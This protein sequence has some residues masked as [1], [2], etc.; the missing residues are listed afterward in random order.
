M[1][2]D[3]ILNVL[4]DKIPEIKNFYEKK[5]QEDLVDDDTGKHIVFGLVVTPYILDEVNNNGENV[6]QIFDFLEDMTFCED[7]K[8]REILDFTI[9][10]QFVDEGKKQLDIL[11]NFM[12]ENTLKCCLEIEKYFIVE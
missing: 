12:H 3:N 7:V 2:Y 6:K 9:L 11:K 1:N 5:K 8:V 4:F 10:E